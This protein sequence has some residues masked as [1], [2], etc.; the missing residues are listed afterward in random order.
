MECSAQ[1][2]VMSGGKRAKER[3]SPPSF[4]LFPP[5]I[6]STSGEFIFFTLG[7][8]EVFSRVPRELRFVGRRPTRVRLKAE[9]TSVKAA[10]K[11]GASGTQGN[12]LR[13][14][15]ISYS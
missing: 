11:T 5:L 1:R 9:D 8:E 14:S 10:R 7:T 12:I 3:K 13:R 2:E 4:A 15:E 6:T